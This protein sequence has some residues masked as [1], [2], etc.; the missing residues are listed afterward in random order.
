MK[1]GPFLPNLDFYKIGFKD[2]NNLI[3]PTFVI[4][5]I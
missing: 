4:P 2:L 3:R 5:F 1:K